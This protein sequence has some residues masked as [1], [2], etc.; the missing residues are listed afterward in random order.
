MRRKIVALTVVFIMSPALAWAQEGYGQFSFNNQSSETADFYVSGAYGCRALAGLFCTTQAR[1]GI[2]T[3]VAQWTNGQSYTIEG[4]ELHQGE[5][6]TM[7]IQD[8]YE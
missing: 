2:H 1:I 8:T 3:L 4:V 5:V 6:L 7:T